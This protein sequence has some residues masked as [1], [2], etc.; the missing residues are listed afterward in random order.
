[1]N[2]SAGSAIIDGGQLDLRNIGPVGFTLLGG[3]NVIFGTER[4]LSHEGDYVFGMSAW[5][6]GFR[7][8]D[9][10]VSWL[11]TWDRHDIA[12]DILGA[13]FKQY[14]FSQF[15]LYGNARYDLTA[16]TFNESLGGISYFPTANLVFTGEYYQSYPTFDATSIYSVFAVNRYQEW[17][18]RG[19]YTINQIIGL[20]AGYTRQSFGDDGHADVYQGGFTLRPMDGLNLGFTL[21]VRNGYNGD[22]VGERL[23]I[24]YDA[25]KALQ[26]AGGF[27]N[28]SYDRN[29]FTSRE[30]NQSAQKYWLA[31]KYLL[32]SNMSTS[33]RLDYDKNRTFSDDVSGRFVFNYDF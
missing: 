24:S 11:R 4:E 17:V 16:E 29:Y 30:E 1:V 13:T 23:D 3:R 28:D 5:L 27:T 33:L 12:R 31:G 32:A 2:L 14:L 10:D 25:T 15:K 26:L 7:H 22:L 18:F 9:L 20:N 6:T 21:D 19:D 8:T